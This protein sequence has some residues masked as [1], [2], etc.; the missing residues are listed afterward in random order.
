MHAAPELSAGAAALI[1]TNRYPMTL[2]LTVY[3]LVILALLLVSTVSAMT[4]AG[5]RVLQV[6]GEDYDGLSFLGR[7]N[8]DGIPST[9]IYM[10]STL[11]TAAYSGL[12]RP[13]RM[14]M[15]LQT[16]GPSR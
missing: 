8:A 9:A 13:S 6:I 12:R 7:T 11:M 2:Q 4:L 15:I 14:T 5:P 16:A 1:R 3:T 10:Q